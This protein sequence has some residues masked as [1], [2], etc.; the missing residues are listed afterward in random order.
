MDPFEIRDDIT[1]LIDEIPMRASIRAIQIIREVLNFIAD[2]GCWYD[3][4]I[5]C[6]RFTKETISFRLEDGADA[7]EIPWMGDRPFDVLEDAFTRWW[8]GGP[9]PIIALN[10]GYA[11]CRQELTN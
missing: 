6:E 2:R 7:P 10:D 5:N 11:T 8:E 1:V 9:E 4:G 3:N